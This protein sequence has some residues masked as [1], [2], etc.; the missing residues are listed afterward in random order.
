MKTLL[1]TAD[2]KQ[3][4]HDYYDIFCHARVDMREH[5]E[6]WVEQIRD[7]KRHNQRPSLEYICMVAELLTAYNELTD[8]CLFIKTKHL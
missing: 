1:H 2:G 3:Y 7:F 5:L 8:F 4:S 6:L